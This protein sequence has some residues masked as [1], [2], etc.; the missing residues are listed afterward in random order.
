M[1]HDRAGKLVLLLNLTTDPE[2][3][4]KTGQILSVEVNIDKE[5]LRVFL[6]HILVHPRMQSCSF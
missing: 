3:T 1:W 2:A 5:K 6:T 4:D